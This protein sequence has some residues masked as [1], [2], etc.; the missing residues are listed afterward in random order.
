MKK[1]DVKVGKTYLC[2]HSSGKIRVRILQEVERFRGGPRNPRSMTHWL[3]TNERTGRQIE[4]KS[5]QKLEPLPE[6]SP[7]GPP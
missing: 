6:V 7:S 4:I 2:N 1:S 3:A 5:A